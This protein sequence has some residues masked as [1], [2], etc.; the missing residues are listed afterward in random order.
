MTSIQPTL[1]LSTLYDQMRDQA[2]QVESIILR[3]GRP[4][5]EKSFER[6]ISSVNHEGCFYPTELRSLQ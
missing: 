4:K 5:R 3:W 2:D 6:K 1:N